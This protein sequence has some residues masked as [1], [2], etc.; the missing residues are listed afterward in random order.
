MNDT[1]EADFVQGMVSAWEPQPDAFVP[2]DEDRAWHAEQLH[3]AS[4]PDA[5][6][7]ASR[8]RETPIRPIVNSH[9]G[10]DPADFVARL[11]RDLAFARSYNTDGMGEVAREIEHTLIECR[12]MGVRTWSE[13]QE[14][15]AARHRGGA[16]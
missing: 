10:L 6:V 7:F 14:A 11:E 1:S 16:R 15:L 2:A 3:I 8:D 5:A 4:D 9:D 13:Y 12:A